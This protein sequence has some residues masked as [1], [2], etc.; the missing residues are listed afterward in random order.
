MYFPDYTDK[1]KNY[2]AWSEVRE[3]IHNFVIQEARTDE[4]LWNDGAPT[5]FIV[6][7]NRTTTVRPPAVDMHGL[8][9]SLSHMYL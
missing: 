2:Q 1:L 6:S 8:L 4:D 9:R 3:F 7:R 5:W